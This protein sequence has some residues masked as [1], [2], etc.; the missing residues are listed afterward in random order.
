MNAWKHFQKHEQKTLF[1]ED[2]LFWW[3]VQK[4]K[5]KII[6]RACITIIVFWVFCAVKRRRFIF[7]INISFQDFK[8]YSNLHSIHFCGKME[9]PHNKNKTIDY[10]AETCKKAADLPFPL[11]LHYIYFIVAKHC[12]TRGLLWQNLN[13]PI[14]QNVEEHGRLPQFWNDATHIVGVS[15]SLFSSLVYIQFLCIGN[16]IVMT[17]DMHLFCFV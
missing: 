15:Y 2:V 14:V 17:E 12:L 8:F 5:N 6:S 3:N 1:C 9:I 10:F 13:I 7:K 11:H 16:A 4:Y